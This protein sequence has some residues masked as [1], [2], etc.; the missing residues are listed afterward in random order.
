MPDEDTVRI[1]DQL[2]FALYAASNAVVRAYR[3]LLHEIG[4]TYPQYLTLMVL[5][6]QDGLAVNQIADR[7]QLPGNALTPLVARLERLGFVS[8]SR[9]DLDR[10]MVHVHLTRQGADLE[11]RAAAVQRQVVCRT[12]L[13]EVSLVALRTQLHD[14]VDDMRAPAAWHGPDEGEGEAS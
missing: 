8:R 7:L 13:D 4:L 12:G 10:R 1:D 11:R 2:C 3:P 5:W 14:L 6:Q 9:D